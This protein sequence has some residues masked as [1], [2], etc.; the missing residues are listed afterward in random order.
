MKGITE[1]Q[2]LAYINLL[3]EADLSASEKMI[4]FAIMVWARDRSIDRNV[5]PSVQ[6]VCECTK[7]S[8][9]SVLRNLASLERKGV[10]RRVRVAGVSNAYDLSAVFA[11]RLPQRGT[12]K[13]APIAAH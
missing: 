12:S 13:L 9:S 8:R 5:W 3:W 11:G 2:V 10:M 4:M 7:L 1:N 6:T